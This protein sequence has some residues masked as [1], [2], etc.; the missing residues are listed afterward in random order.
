MMKKDTIAA[1]ATSSKNG[2]ISVIRVS[3]D[4]ALSRISDIFYRRKNNGFEKID[5]TV[6]ETHTIHYGFI[7][8]ENAE[9]LDE[10]L[11]M[12]M[13][14]PRS[15]TAENVV[16]IQCH[17]GFMVCRLVMKCL[18]ETGVR[19]AEPGEFTK[20]AFLNGR[21]DL[22]QAESVMDII[23]ADSELALGNSISQLRGNIKNKI[24]SLREILL[25]DIAFLEAALDDPEHISL[26]H[27]SENIE[28]H[29]EILK[30]EI[31]HLLKNGENGRM[32][33]EGIRT[34]IVGKP[35]VGKSS[36]MNRILRDDRAIVT[37]IPGTTRD[38]LEEELQI[39]STMLRLIDTAGIHETDDVVE[40]IGIDKARKS[41]EDAD[42]VLCILDSNAPL[43]KED[44]DILES[45]KEKEGIILLNKSDL[46][47]A[48]GEE[49]LQEHSSILKKK[50]IMKFSAVSGEGLE[51]LEQ[52]ITDMVFDEAIDYNH[53]IYITNLRQKQALMETR[54]SLNHLSESI[55]AGMPEDLFSIDMTDAYESLGKIIGE[56][57]EDDIIDKIFKDFCMGK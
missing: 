4:E 3:G 46:D 21:I 26:D 52:K 28:E 44:I 47:S 42:F 22:S 6:C 35:N 55:E 9:V 54:D 50:K 14:A 33:K 20:R 23:R 43:S 1:I 5:L 30:K 12:V 2:S 18:L 24:Q 17:G 32:M 15:Y 25:E 11:V 16:E 41:V 51:Q 45:C 39:G 10:V 53:D 36:F 27:Y 34:V 7:C 8:N 29:V 40:N 48:F 56:T 38:T 13:K 37:D 31:L 19:I 57:I 49:E